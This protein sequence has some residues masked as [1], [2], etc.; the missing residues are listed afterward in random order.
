MTAF[1]ITM[2]ILNLAALIFIPM[3]AVR[4]GR[5]LQ[6]QADTRKDKMDI[7]KTLMANRQGWSM[8]SVRAMNIIDIVFA[9]DKDVREC[10]K[11]YYTLLCIQ[12]PNEMQSQ[13]IYTAQ[14]RLL[15]AM[16]VSLGYKDKITWENIQSPYTP[17]GMKQVVDQQQAILEGQTMFAQATPALI[18]LLLSHQTFQQPQ[19]EPLHEDEPYS[20]V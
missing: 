2:S 1:E 20:D 6:N 8:E 5:N 15:E 9:D 7:F 10:W 18:Q 17:K 14:V 12:Q 3:F 4:V 13:Q 16:A 11:K 19:H